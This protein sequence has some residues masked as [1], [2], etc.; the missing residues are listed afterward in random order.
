MSGGKQ[1]YGKEE[2]LKRESRVQREIGKWGGKR[3]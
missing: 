3:N 1:Q 2:E